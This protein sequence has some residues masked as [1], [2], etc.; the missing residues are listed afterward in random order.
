MSDDLFYTPLPQEDESEITLIDPNKN[1]YTNVIESFDKNELNLKIEKSE[2]LPV[3]RFFNHPTIFNWIGAIML[4]S[5]IE[6]IFL[7]LSF[8]LKVGACSSSTTFISLDKY[9][10][11]SSVS[12]FIT[13]LI[14]S[15]SMNICKI[16]DISSKNY[17]NR[18]QSCILVLWRF[19]SIIMVGVG[20]C[21]IIEI[22]CTAPKGNDNMVTVT[23]MY[24]CLKIFYLICECF[25]HLQSDYILS[26]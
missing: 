23:I 15:L 10:F 5:L 6:S 9:L 12:G 21:I 24:I 26:E 4:C 16:S 1:V 14:I 11:I 7:I 18:Y 8:A 17:D 2:P 22:N 13:P 3:N 19:F 25:C 20:I